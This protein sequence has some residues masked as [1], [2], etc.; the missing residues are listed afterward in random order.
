MFYPSAKYH[1]KLFKPFPFFRGHCASEPIDC[2]P[3]TLSREAGSAI[4][5]SLVGDSAGPDCLL[6]ATPLRN[7]IQ[8]L[9]IHTFL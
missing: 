3:L 5:F 9:T 8:E 7:K 6:S 1:K 4:S 2:P